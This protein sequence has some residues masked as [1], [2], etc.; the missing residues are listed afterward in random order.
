M[1]I[2]ARILGLASALV[3]AIGGLVVVS[4]LAPLHAQVQQSGNVTPNHAACWSANGVLKDCGTSSTG[5]IPSLGLVNNGGY[6]FCINSGAAPGSYYQEC[7]GVGGVGGTGFWALNALGGASPIPFQ[8]QLNGA[9]YT[10]GNATSPVF[11]SSAM[12]F[13]PVSPGLSSVY[14][15]GDGS[16]GTPAGTGTVVG[17]VSS[18]IGN[19]ATWANNV[20][21]TIKNGPAP[22]NTTDSVVPLVHNTT[23]SGHFA[24]FNDSQGTLID[25]GYAPPAA[26]TTIAGATG[27]FTP[28]D[29]LKAND[30]YGTVADSGV[31]MAA[32]GP[33]GST[34]PGS[35]AFT[36]LS[37]NSTVSGTG[38]STYLA[39]PPAIGGTAAAA[40]TFTQ[41]V[42]Q[43]LNAVEPPQG[44][45]TLTSG[46]PVQRSD[47][48]S[49]TTVYYDSYAGNGVPLVGSAGLSYLQIASNEISM[50]LATA[51]VT[52]GN[53]Y[54]IFAVNNSNAL[55]IC[56][57]AAWTNGTTRSAAI[58]V[59][60][61]GFWTNTSSLTHCYGGASGTT[62][63]G[64]VTAG[65][66]TYLG[67]LYA[68][69][70]GQTAMKLQPAFAAGGN[71]PVMGLYNAYNQVRVLAREGDST[72]QWS[73]S[74]SAWRCAD[75][76][77]TNSIIWVDGLGQSPIDASYQLP[78]SIASTG[79]TPAMGVGVNTS[80]ASAAPTIGAGNTSTAMTVIPWYTAGLFYPTLGLHY[81]LAEEYGSAGG[82]GTTTWYGVGSGG[83]VQTMVLTVRGDS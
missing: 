17:P 60:S 32:P 70:N 6:G 46:V 48:L 69:A 83:P 16:W 29:L 62:D 68:I 14:L 71:Q 54:D 45:L 47:V 42:A 33:I 35:G 11:N 4:D 63:Y 28:G 23:T 44:R 50:G 82:G 18:A 13:V 78:V 79:T 34:T 10:I 61:Y 72:S 51:N 30:I 52:S 21:T 31:T 43:D 8:L 53:L 59:N 75:N 80:A 77:C 5:N 3:L 55:A 37:A 57:G 56:V 81:Y 38:F 19:F 49:A 74:A 67:T 25:N 40:G 73:Y 15:R 12:G 7:F 1:S 65:Y 9:N 27:T 64:S 66:A 58:S 39:S 22:S 24:S 76:S 26:S 41:L 2:R 36:T 20:G